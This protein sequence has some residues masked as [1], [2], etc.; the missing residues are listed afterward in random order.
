VN[1]SAELVLFESTLVVTTIST[2]P[3]LPAGESAVIVLFWLLVTLT[4]VEAFVP[5]LTV[6]RLLSHARLVPVIVTAVPPVVKP[7]VGLMPVMVGLL[8]PQ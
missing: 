1:R 3:A 7:E 8:D 6:G 2:V 4:F 5:N